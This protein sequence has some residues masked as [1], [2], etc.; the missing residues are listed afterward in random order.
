MYHVNACG[1][2]NNPIVDKKKTHSRY[3][4][5]MKSPRGGS[6]YIALT[7]PPLPPAHP[8]ENF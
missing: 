6:D 1:Q 7:P 2:L 5:A 8:T 3:D 4:G